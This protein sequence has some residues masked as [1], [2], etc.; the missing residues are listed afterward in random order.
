[1]LGAAMGPNRQQGSCWIAAS[2]CIGACA[3]LALGPELPALFLGVALA[4]GL[5]TLST[6]SPTWIRLSGGLAVFGAGL[7]FALV[8]WQAMALAQLGTEHLRSPDSAV[9]AS[10]LMDGQTILASDWT[11]NGTWL[12]YAEEGRPVRLE[13]EGRSLPRGGRAASTRLLLPHLGSALSTESAS[14][15]ILG[16][17]WGE[18]SAGLLAQQV[19]QVTLAVPQPTL[20]QALAAAEPALNSVWLHPALRL[21]RGSPEEVLRASGEVDLI[22]EDA[23]TPWRDGVQGLPS[24]AGL[25]LRSHRLSASGAY[26]LVVP[27]IHMDE[28][29]LRGLMS[30]FAQQFP[31]TMVFLP[32][33]GADQLIF[34]GWHGPKLRD[35]DRVVQASVRGGE[36]LATVGI[37][38][39]L[40]LADLALAPMEGPLLE[41]GGLS[42]GWMRLGPSLHRRPRMLPPVFLPYLSDQP[43]VDAPEDVQQ[44][45]SLR[46][47][48]NRALLGCLDSAARGEIQEVVNQC[49]ALGMSPGGE[50]RLDPLIAPQLETAGRALERGDTQ[51]CLREVEQARLLNPK[52]AEAHALAGKCRLAQGDG[53][54]AKED[55]EKAESLEP[56]NLDALLGLAQLAV[57]RGDELAAE[58][59]LQTAAQ[60]NPRSWRPPYYLGM[61]LL[62]QGRLEDAD[63]QLANARGLSGEDSTLPLAGLAHVAILQDA[64]QLALTQ[65]RLA[66][67]REPSPRNLHLVGWAYLS[68][69]SPEAARPFLERAILADSNYLPA[70]ADLGRVFAIQGEYGMAID[71]FDRVLALEPGNPAAIQNRQRAA[72]LQELESQGR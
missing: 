41:G 64:P 18:L 23:G 60:R 55:F 26:L 65:A 51:L 36:L 67:D 14:A 27:A 37:Q 9:K 15:L 56:A 39:P 71:A 16:D 34:A 66:A 20:T 13:R 11:P 24:P 52:S 3:S 29:A 22:L 47:E 28:A 1:A 57:A 38:A 63:A 6:P 43:W 12:L 40:D 19:G 4:G 7:I 68:L 30:A 8:P 33:Q 50:R 49:R 48:T 59:G 32:P 70:H 10:L 5:L 53:R 31:N 61:L 46:I 54:R 21:S 25:A 69:G 44:A 62:D 2:A 42:Y 45:L 17:P 72:A 35:W 58:R